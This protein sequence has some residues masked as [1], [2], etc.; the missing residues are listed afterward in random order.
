MRRTFTD[1]DA[2]SHDLDRDNGICIVE[3][4]Q[5]KCRREAYDATTGINRRHF[6]DYMHITTTYRLPLYLAFVDAKVGLIM[7]TPGQN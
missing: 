4:K 1:I 5:P 3:V 7:G 6:D 2:S